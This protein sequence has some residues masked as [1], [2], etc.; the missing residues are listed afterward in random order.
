MRGSSKACTKQW[1]EIPYGQRLFLKVF[2]FACISSFQL[3]L[4]TVQDIK[5]TWDILK[6]KHR[7]A[8]SP[9]CGAI[10]IEFKYIEKL[11]HFADPEHATT[12]VIRTL[13][14]A[15]PGAFTISTQNI[16]TSLFSIVTVANILNTLELNKDADQGDLVN[17]LVKTIV[18]DVYFGQEFFKKYTILVDA[19]LQEYTSQVE[20]LNRALEVAQ[21]RRRGIE[22]L[23][24]FGVDTNAKKFNPIVALK[25]AKT[26]HSDRAAEI[27]AILTD[28][29]KKAPDQKRQK[30][31]KASAAHTSCTPIIE[32]A[33]A[34]AQSLDECFD[35][36]DTSRLYRPYTTQQAFLAWIYK[37][38]QS[39]A[40]FSTFFKELNDD[41]LTRDA[42]TNCDQA[43]IEDVYQENEENILHEKF[44]TELNSQAGE[45][46]FNFFQGDEFSG[47]VLVEIM[48]QLFGQSVPFLPEHGSITFEGITFADCVET[49]IRNLC[50]VVTY[51]K[52]VRTFGNAK[53]FTLLQVLLDFYQQSE[54]N[55][56]EANTAKSEVRQSWSTLVE[57]LPNI[58]YHRAKSK[59]HNNYYFVCLG[60]VDGFIK[61][62][63]IAIPD[64]NVEKK[65]VTLSPRNLAGQ[66]ITTVPAQNF[67]QITV[68]NRTYL[69][70]SDDNYHL[71]E[72]M[73]SI[74][75]IVLMLNNFFSLNLFAATLLT[76][77]FFND[78]FN[79][80][81]FYT[82]CEKLNWSIVNKASLN[83]NDETKNQNITLNSAFRL[84]IFPGMHA[85][86]QRLETALKLVAT[87]QKT[88]NDYLLS[89]LKDSTPSLFL[90]LLF[91]IYT[92]CNV[93][94]VEFDSSKDDF[95]DF[96]RCFLNNIL[97]NETKVSV[98]NKIAGNLD[99]AP[100]FI[101]LFCRLI[102]SFPILDDL[103]WQIQVARTFA[104]GDF[105]KK[106]KNNE[107]L[108]QT[109]QHLTQKV[110]DHTTNADAQMKVFEHLV[111][112]LVAFNLQ[113]KI[114]DII[115]FA[116]KAPDFFIILLRN[117][118][119]FEEAMQWIHENSILNETSIDLLSILITK[120]HDQALLYFL[121]NFEKAT[122]LN[123]TLSKI[124]ISKIKD[125]NES[126]YERVMQLCKKQTDLDNAN[127]TA[128]LLA[129]IEQDYQPAI[130][131][132][133]NRPEG[134]VFFN[135]YMLELFV[136]MIK[137]NNA[138]ALD[139]AMKIVEKAKNIDDGHMKE[140]LI[141]LVKQ[142][143][144]PAIKKAM[145]I[146]KN[147]DSDEADCALLKA[148]IEI[149]CQ[150]AI[151]KAE[152]IFTQESLSDS[153]R[154]CE[155]VDLMIKKNND[156]ARDLAMS[157]CN[158]INAAYT[159]QFFRTLINKDYEPA[160]QQAISLASANIIS[161]AIRA[162][163]LF[164]ILWAK[165]Y[166]INEAQQLIESLGDS[167][168]KNRLK[169]ALDNYNAAALRPLNNLAT[170]LK[171]L[172]AKLAELGGK[173]HDLVS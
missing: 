172:K 4:G 109:I 37:K 84:A 70:V 16:P 130:T 11:Y 125:K 93:V 119:A 71:F 132:S 78:D 116:K 134:K 142:N 162:R 105:I 85:F 7:L 56:T 117:N 27:E 120:N 97:D 94:Y 114:Q 149:N 101:A 12:K 95:N 58:A 10:G 167:V 23:K 43:W 26:D 86:A 40:E 57:N 38:A 88:I 146:L 103:Y 137:K 72:V 156:F 3:L 99:V 163:M 124:I 118:L 126:D 145:E 123:D 62:D 74:R 169:Q 35:G 166:A 170:G 13:F 36:V 53:T 138:V 92:R 141:A 147:F 79:S 18:S 73:P 87:Y 171:A 143:Y 155:V 8:L 66:V 89:K 67:T 45:F 2:L 107:Q 28:W 90:P 31:I 64:G 29:Q 159:L 152:N 91:D 158:E 51:N 131:F 80:T 136:A 63:G 173:L 48:L 65:E 160:I 68:N 14:N 168:N 25:K 60:G 9:V 46:I 55:R 44:Q 33:R 112:T 22:L 96:Y 154:E 19:A 76:D 106:N 150:E 75:N 54:L 151:D 128:I 122:K 161:S 135:R 21:A 32:F 39:K 108:K 140:L 49:T 148:L 52:E 121:A 34:I 47:I 144:Q 153:T 113:D 102:H 98:I 139:K 104:L 17:A 50:N 111:Q 30:E 82:L 5:G 15:P 133:L 41:F 1:V 110:L 157:Y 24:T 127:V 77:I 59:D 6:P 61:F 69:V 164:G 20:E 100:H 165:G 115:T 83:L 81:Y 42:D 129:M